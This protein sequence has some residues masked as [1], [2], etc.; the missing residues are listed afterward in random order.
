MKCCP[1]LLNPKPGKLRDTS[2]VR[3][4]GCG[5]GIV[6]GMRSLEKRH[7]RDPNAPTTR[8]WVLERAPLHCT[9][10]QA[11]D[12]LATAFSEVV[13]VKQKRNRKGSFFFFRV[14]HRTDCDMVALPVTI[15]DSQTL[16]LWG[17]MGP[18]PEPGST[19]TH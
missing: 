10:Q 17:R 7:R 14:A 3:A 13:M 6:A 2:R 9:A 18:G 1:R 4:T 11:Q 5:Y 19:P 8:T 12:A 15:E 16:L